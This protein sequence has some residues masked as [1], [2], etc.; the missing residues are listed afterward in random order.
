MATVNVAYVEKARTGGLAVEMET[1]R[2]QQVREDKRRCA[3]CNARKGTAEHAVARC[4]EFDQ[5]RDEVKLKLREIGLVDDCPWGVVIK[6]GVEFRKGVEGTL[7]KR[8]TALRA[9]NG[10]IRKV[11]K[12]KRGNLMKAT[13]EQSEE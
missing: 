1:G 3:D 9:L 13:K 12:R 2:W 4:R 6:G 7:E 11:D 8:Q 10:F 5:P